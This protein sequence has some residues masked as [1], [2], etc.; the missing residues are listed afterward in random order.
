MTTATREKIQ[1]AYSTDADNY[2]HVR[3]EDTKGR[4]LSEHDQRIFSSLFPQSQGDMEVLEVGAGTGRFTVLALERGFRLTATDINEEMLRL[5]KEKAASMNASDRCT[6][7]ILDVFNPTLEKASFD[8]VFSLHVIPRFLTVEDQQAAIK[9][10]ASLIKPGG[11]FLFNYRNRKSFY[12]LMYKGP[13]ATPRQI[14]QA[15]ESS[16]MRIETQR[17]K[18]LVNKRLLLKLPVFVGKIVI[19]LDGMMLRCWTNRSWD[20]FVVAVKDK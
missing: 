3:L 20:V 7:L 4:I 18:W 1:E 15:L 2:D 11:R 17:G 14:R 13:A 16:G 19:A 12:N 6:V 5:L 9:S 10:I 8:Y